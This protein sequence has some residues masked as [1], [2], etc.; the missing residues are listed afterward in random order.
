MPK[1]KAIE[2]E[3]EVQQIDTSGMSD[4]QIVDVICDSLDKLCTT[5]V[6]RGM[7]EELVTASLFRLFA[8]RMADSGDRETYE[9][10][11]EIALEEPWEE[12]VLH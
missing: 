7:D 5:L 1:K 11:L 10:V 8:E 12:I 2:Q 9:E 3:V 4:E 6:E